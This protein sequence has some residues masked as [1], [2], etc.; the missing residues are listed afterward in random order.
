EIENFKGIRD[1]VRID[2][3]PITL[4][5]GPNS[6]GKSTIL[7]AIQYAQEV[8]ERHNLDVERP[9]SS[10][11]MVDL[12]GFRNVVHQR[13]LNRAV[14]LR[15]EVDVAR[16]DWDLNPVTA[17]GQV[18]TVHLSEEDLPILGVRLTSIEV[19]VEI[20]WSELRNKP[21][22]SRYAVGIDGQPLAAIVC[23]YN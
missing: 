1:R 15:F 18:F 9:Q 16:E 19:D 3:K 23:E 7:H 10:G 20:T 8:F 17:V 11:G 22:V 12:G 5:F 6:A 13:D 2:L 14:R 21:Y 4:L